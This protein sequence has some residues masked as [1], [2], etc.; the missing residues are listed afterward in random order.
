MPGLR[1]S[2][3]QQLPD[4]G[5]A[6]GA[7]LSRL[8]VTGL[9]ALGLLALACGGASESSGQSEQD[10][11]KAIA[12]GEVRY[13][14]LTKEDKTA[15]ARTADGGLMTIHNVEDLDALAAVLSKERVE[16]YMQ[17]KHSAQMPE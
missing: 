14:L 4:P 15:E 3:E 1:R 7:L 17:D 13:A 5:I 6:A 12:R 10:L 16:Y 8:C 9:L 11:Y 2:D